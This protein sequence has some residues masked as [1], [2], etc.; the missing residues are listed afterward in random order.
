MEVPAFSGT[1]HVCVL[2]TRTDIVK[3]VVTLDNQ[4]IMTADIPGRDSHSE[5]STQEYCAMSAFVPNIGFHELKVLV[6]GFGE[7]NKTQFTQYPN[8]T[9]YL[10]IYINKN[11]IPQKRP[12][13]LIILKTNI[14]GGM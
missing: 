7:V 13:C 4:S 9:N 3:A 6:N 10:S 8:I 1:L 5:K 11:E 12:G 14:T 2:N